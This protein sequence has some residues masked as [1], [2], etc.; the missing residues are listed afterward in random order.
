MHYPAC[1]KCGCAVFQQTRLATYEEVYEVEL[2]NDGTIER[3][4]RKDYEQ[5]AEEVRSLHRC[6]KCG[7]VL[8]DDQGTQLLK[9]EEIK[10]L[11][12]LYKDAS[13]NAT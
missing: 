2:Y 9:A 13:E 1:I 3:S 12:E 6:A 11:V 8:A 4:Y 5:Y 7:W 10:R